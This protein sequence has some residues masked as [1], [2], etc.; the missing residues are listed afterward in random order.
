MPA[1]R[2]VAV[3]I[4]CHNEA[5]TIAKVVADFRTALP[6]AHIH[7]F[8]NASSDDT[9]R[10]A[11]QA[12]AQVHLVPLP[13]KGNVVRRMFADV[14]ADMYLVVDGDDTYDASRAPALLDRLQIGSCDMV[15]GVRDAAASAAYRRG[16][17]FGNRLLT[18]F[19]SR[20]FGRDCGDILSGYRAFSRRFV[21]SFPVF[22][23]GFEIETELTVHALEMSMQVGE[24]PTRY[25][26]RPEGS[27][28]KLKTY[29]D[30][31]RIAFTI[32]RLFSIERPLA[33]YG[34]IA[35]VFAS[36]SILLAVPVFQTY[37]ETGLVPRFPTAILSTG[38]MLLSAL[39]F[40]AGLILAT[41]T[42]GRQESK[43]LAYLQQCAPESRAGDSGRCVHE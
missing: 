32:V 3:L 19:L 15:V 27:A 11:A 6:E 23:S 5:T 7:V 33:F 16:H 34:G 22:S 8:D 39:S 29:R 37:L 31:A 4:P 38:L 14:D 20:L 21:K 36:I 42:R 10:V 9:A 28:S 30:G 24:V 13:G 43:A 41:V 18:R 2:R 40:F 35:A 1:A 25:R 12:G 26:E 17:A